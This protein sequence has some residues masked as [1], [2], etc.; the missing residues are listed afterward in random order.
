MGGLDET[1]AEAMVVVMSLMSAIIIIINAG[2]IYIIQWS[3]VLRQKTASI[4][5]Y[6]ILTLH[7]LQGCFV[8]PFYA[9]KKSKIDSI[10]S[11]KF[12]CD[13]F[14]FS[15]MITF[16][17]ACINVLLIG[18]DRLLAIRLM[19]SYKLVVT[20]RRAIIATIS[21]WTYV[22]VLCL[23]PFVPPES[24]K[25]C[26]YNQQDEWTT[27]MLFFN[28]LLPYIFVIVSYMYITVKLDEIQQKTQA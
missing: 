22:L 12:I 24:E 21:L 10:E 9:A 28:T 26:R 20:R 18:G 4:F 1:F 7:L 16:Y 11:K 5:V 13:G 19:T 25:F 2:C 3:S 17:G 27:F 23:I 14:R 6:S 8:I 15:Y